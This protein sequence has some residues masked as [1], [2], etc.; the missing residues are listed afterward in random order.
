MGVS[1]AVG[2]TRGRLRTTYEGFGSTYSINSD[3]RHSA[4]AVS[5][6][7]LTRRPLFTTDLSTLP[8]TLPSAPVCILYL[9]DVLCVNQH[10]ETEA[11]QCDVAP[12]T[13]SA[14][15]Q[16]CGGGTIVVLDS[17]RCSPAT[18]AWCIFEWCVGRQSH[19]GCQRQL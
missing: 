1:M 3:G 4:G 9:Q 15:V 2:A 18:R 6:V 13:F 16:A 11:H 19:E 7:A 14:V 5:R 8:L 17:E 10:E 12:A